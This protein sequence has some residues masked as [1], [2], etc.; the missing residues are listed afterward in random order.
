M[1]LELVVDASMGGVTADGP[2]LRKLEKSDCQV[3]WLGDLQ[4]LGL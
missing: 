4:Q 3:V 2:L 1:S